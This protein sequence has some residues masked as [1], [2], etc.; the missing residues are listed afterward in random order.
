MA[1]SWGL[2]QALSYLDHLELLGEAE[3]AG[4]GDLDLWALAA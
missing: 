4:D 2:S 1:V 3:R